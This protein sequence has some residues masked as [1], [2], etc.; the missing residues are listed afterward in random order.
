LTK[1]EQNLTTTINI[2]I[3]SNKEV[4]TPT[5]REEVQDMETPLYPECDLC[6]KT[7]KKAADGEYVMV[8]GKNKYIHN[9]KCLPMVKRLLDR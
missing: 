3:V 1:S 6:G 2:P 8:L 9:K 5:G 4:K 7:I